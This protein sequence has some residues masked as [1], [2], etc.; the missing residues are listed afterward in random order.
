M[1]L[2]VLFAIILFCSISSNAQENNNRLSPQEL[3]NGWELLFDGETLNGWRSYDEKNEIGWIVD[4]ASLHYNGAKGV[5]DLMT[6]EMYGDFD[7][8]FTWK[9]MGNSGVIYRVRAE[10]QWG[11]PYQTGPEFQV[12]DDAGEF[13]K[14]STGSFYDVIETSK[15][16]KVLN[17]PAWNTGR[18]RLSNGLVTHWVNDVIVMQCELYSEAWNEKVAQSKW[19]N[20]PY[21]GKSPF[22]HIDFQNHGAKVWYKDLK[23]KKL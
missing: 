4:E 15:D 8:K 23:I 6:A 17:Y 16:K 13:N 18:I 2:K 20:N 9:T 19:K 7:F 3:A 22:G 5:D 11:R 12:H 1:N 10:N 21:Y 14:N